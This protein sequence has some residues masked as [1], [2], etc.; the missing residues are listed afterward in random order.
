MNINEQVG[1]KMYNDKKQSQDMFS[2][3]YI[4]TSIYLGLQALKK[5]D[6]LLEYL[7]ADPL[8]PKRH[9]EFLMGLN[10]LRGLG[11]VDSVPVYDRVLKILMDN[12][13][14]P[15]VM[16]LT[17]KSGQWY[18]KAQEPTKTYTLNNL[19]QVQALLIKK[20][21]LEG[22]IKKV[23]NNDNEDFIEVSR[24]LNSLDFS[25][26]EENAVK[27]MLVSLMEKLS[28]SLLQRITQNPTDKELASSLISTLK[29][30]SRP[31]PTS[32]EAFLISLLNHMVLEPK[33]REL[34]EFLMYCL[35]KAPGI[36]GVNSLNIYNTI[37]DLFECS[38]SQKDLRV[39][40]LDV[41][42]WHFSR[43]NWLRRSPKPEDEQ[44]MQNDILMRL[45]S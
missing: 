19:S 2:W 40:V 36:A 13:N 1:S 35:D 32:Y 20:E 29:F 43:K 45:K 30:V 28:A 15:E 6:E 44:Q 42:R 3:I 41:G 22:L 26:F 38:S 7:E 39:L 5:R 27:R 25:K 11:N 33:N 37:L 10:K 31:D 8:N 4:G 9:Q 34:K 12:P 17:F 18:F 23:E 14:D 16:N 24:W 21:E